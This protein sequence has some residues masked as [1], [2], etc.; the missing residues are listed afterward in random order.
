MGQQAQ[1]EKERVVFIVG[2]SLVPEEF[3]VASAAQT[4]LVNAGSNGNLC[5]SLSRGH[6]RLFVLCG[7][8][9][10]RAMEIGTG[11]PEN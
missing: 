5:A 9:R 3:T 6:D 2:L 10:L 8:P 7:D 11:R 4:T 1:L